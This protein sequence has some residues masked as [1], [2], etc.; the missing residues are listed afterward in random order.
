M[1][2]YVTYNITYE[3]EVSEGDLNN[4]YYN[5]DVEDPTWA[6]EYSPDKVADYFNSMEMD[7]EFYDDISLEKVNLPNDTIFYR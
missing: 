6:D 7:W 5:D 4:L 2:C 3:V 1:K